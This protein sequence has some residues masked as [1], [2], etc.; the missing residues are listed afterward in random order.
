MTNILKPQKKWCDVC[1]CFPFLSCKFLKSLKQ[2][3]TSSYFILEA[4][5]IRPQ[6]EIKTLQV[7]IKRRTNRAVC[8]CF[9]SASVKHRRETP[10]RARWKPWCAC[11][12]R[13][14]AEHCGWCGGGLATFSRGLPRRAGGREQRRERRRAGG[15]SG[16]GFG[17]VQGLLVAW[18]GWKRVFLGTWNSGRKRGARIQDKW[19][20]CCFWCSATGWW[21]CQYQSQYA[22]FA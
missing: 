14:S 10:N 9:F 8:G 19:T 1:G 5:S 3:R 11:K 4:L 2:V 20:P 18:W 21:V 6:I 13:G 22:L 17:R 7:S 16:F 12:W 15:F